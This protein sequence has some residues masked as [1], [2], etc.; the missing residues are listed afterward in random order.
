MTY[1]RIHRL[2]SVVIPCYNAEHYIEEC[3]DHLYQQ[4]YKDMEIIIVDDNSKDNSV[5]TIERWK[6]R[7]NF[8]ALTLLKLPR[9]VGFSGALTCGFFLA[10]GEYIAIHDADDYSHRDRLLKQVEYLETHQDIDFVGTNYLAFQNESV[11]EKSLSNWLS[12]DEDIKARYAKGDHCVSHPTAM[13][14]ASAFDKIGGLTR[15]MNG[16]EDY[17]YV[18][19]FIQN[20][21]GINNLPDVLYYYRLHAEQRSREFYS[22]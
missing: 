1:P 18:V 10:Q 17:E 4:T 13:F 8:T 22:F 20:G 3:L 9:N 6:A 12:Y 5:D 21:Y 11:H 2:V 14:R 15:N 16:A 7:T 19:K